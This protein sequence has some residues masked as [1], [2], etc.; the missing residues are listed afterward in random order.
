[1]RSI[2][3]FLGAV[4]CVAIL[5]MLTSGIPFTKP[6]K[7]GKSRKGEMTEV[8]STEPYDTIW[9]PSRDSISCS[10]FE[11]TL[12]ATHESLYVSNRSASDMVGL[13]IEIEYSDMKD[14]MLHKA[15]HDVSVNI[16]AGETRLVDIP[17]FDRQGLY[18][19]YL[20]P[21]Q[22]RASRATPFKA[23]AKILYIL[24]PRQ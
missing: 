11:K 7:P 1:M 21:A 8:K 12:R 14:R 3:A 4:I 20:S 15:L 16:P 13:G 2:R 17:S 23:K 22:T 5:V 9:V 24:I 10:G 6:S 19:Y 18:Y